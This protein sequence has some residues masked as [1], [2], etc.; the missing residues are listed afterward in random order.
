[1]FISFIFVY[2]AYIFIYKYVYVFYKHIN[3]Y[4][5]IFIHFCCLKKEGLADQQLNLFNG[6]C[7]NDRVSGKVPHL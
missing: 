3:M 1:M 4:K 5:H 6:T 7:A 2:Y